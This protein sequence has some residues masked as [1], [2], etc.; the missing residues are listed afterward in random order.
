MPARRAYIDGRYGQMH[1]RFSQPEAPSGKRPLLLFHM[2]PNSSLIYDRFVREMGRDRL[3][4]AIDTPGFGESDPPPSPPEIADYAAAMGD[5]MDG[6]GLA[7]VDLMGFHTGSKIALA[8]ARAR[9]EQVHR[10]VIVSATVFTDAELAEHRAMYAPETLADDGSHLAQWWK[11][12]KRWQMEGVTNAMLQE[13]FA[14]HI[15]HPAISWWG[16]RAAFNFQMK[17]ELP[18]AEHPV[19]ILNP[20]DDLAAF[21]PRARPLLKHPQSRV[22]DLPGWAHGFLDLKTQETAALVREFLD[23]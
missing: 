15:A 23:G 20:D 21:T 2:S 22:H 16:H 17:D 8:L 18:K 1:Y 4:I 19:L 5:V 3:A 9:P 14:T 11:A 10:A 12:S 13:T 6:L 7:A